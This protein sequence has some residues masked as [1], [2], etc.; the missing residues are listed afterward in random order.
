[1]GAVDLRV[2]VQ[3]RHGET[4]MNEYLRRFR[5]SSRGHSFVDPGLRD[6]VLTSTGKEQAQRLRQNLEALPPPEVIV[7]SPLSRALQTADI[8]FPGTHQRQES[9]YHM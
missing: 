7:A 2:C 6:T 1:M 9:L 4:E 3:I 8:A 5:S